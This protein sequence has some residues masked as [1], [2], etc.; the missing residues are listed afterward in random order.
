MI[1]LTPAERVLQSLGIESPAEIDLEAIAWT[2]GA[3]VNYRP[4]DRCEATIDLSI[5]GDDPV[6]RSVAT[7]HRLL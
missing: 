6:S 4:L 7:L 3:V 5:A 2:R 1:A